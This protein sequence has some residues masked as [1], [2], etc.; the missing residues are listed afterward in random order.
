M[1]PLEPLF[2]KRYKFE[3]FDVIDCVMWVVRLLRFEP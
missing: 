1:I 2:S 3:N